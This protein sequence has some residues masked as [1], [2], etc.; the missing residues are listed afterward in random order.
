M[1]LRVQGSASVQPSKL[2]NWWG[3]GLGNLTVY[4]ESS[5]VQANQMK[6]AARAKSAL[7]G[8]IVA[9]HLYKTTKDFLKLKV[10]QNYSVGGKNCING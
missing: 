2:N 7:S 3:A 6:A 5:S 8:H 10:M 9:K 4:E 1:C